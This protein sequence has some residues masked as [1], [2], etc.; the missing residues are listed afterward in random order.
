[1]LGPDGTELARGLTAYAASDAR[2]IA[3][4]KTEEV[5]AILG[6]SGRPALV[7]RDDLVLVGGS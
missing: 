3:G 5:E 1:M 4:R 2:R 7:H 6:W